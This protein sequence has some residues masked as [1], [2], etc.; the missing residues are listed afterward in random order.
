MKYLIIIVLLFSIFIQIAAFELFAKPIEDKMEEARTINTL[1]IFENKLF[2][3]YG[4]YGINTGPTDIIYYNF[5]DCTWNNAFTIQEEAIEHYVEI[6][7]KLYIPGVDAT[8]NWDFGNYYICDGIEWEKKRNIPNGIH[9]FDIEKYNDRLY[10]ATGNFLKTDSVNGLAPG[11][12]LSSEHGNKWIYDYISPSDKN[13]VYRITDLIVYNDKLMAFYYG[14]IG[15]EK[16]DIPEEYHQYLSNPIV[17]DSIEYYLVTIPDIMGQSDVLVYN[18]YYWKL[19]NIISA[20]NIISIKPFVFNDKLLMFTLQGKY[21]RGVSTYI[22][23]HGVL[24]K[25]VTSSLYMNN[26]EKTVKINMDFDLIID[27]ASYDNELY[28][29]ILKGKDYIVLRTNNMQKWSS[30]VIPQNAGKILSFAIYG[31]HV[32]LGNDIGEIYKTER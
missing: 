28:M 13:L 22:K 8:D 5:M 26:G 17:Q 19:E 30:T 1:H 21:V 23:E 20:D 2:I 16:S 14:Y 10:C 18:D 15:L 7:N 25:N 29:L 4:D 32:F 11:A 24:P 31:D 12:V 6:D 3:G 9:V 27:L